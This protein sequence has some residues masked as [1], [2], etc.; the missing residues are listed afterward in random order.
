MQQSQGRVSYDIGRMQDDMA[1]LG[2]L[3]VDLA[4]HAQVSHMTVSRFLRGERQTARTA[5]KLAG[6]LGYSVRRYLISSR[7]LVTR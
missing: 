2:W 4:R 3:P 6:A 5:K 1:E 7:E